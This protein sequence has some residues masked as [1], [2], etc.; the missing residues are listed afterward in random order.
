MQSVVIIGG[1][2][3]IGR[4]LAL[5][6]S[7][8]Q[9]VTATYCKTPQENSGNLTYVSQDVLNDFDFPLPESVDH[10]V[11]CPGA[12]NLKPFHA[13]K[14]DSFVQDY[15]LQVVGAVK[16]IQ[17]CLKLLKKSDQASITLFSSVASQTGFPFHSQV[18]ASKGAIEGL[19][20]A[21]AAELSPKIRVNVIAPSLT[22]TPLANHFIN[23]EAKIE[24]NKA[25]HPMQ[26]I[27]H[28]QDITHA[29]KYLQS[30]HWVT[31]QVIKVDGGISSIR[32]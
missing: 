13:L 4:D 7:K 27:G 23:N 15:Q 30:A 9:A 18:S 5:E 16:A 26:A 19:A 24:A 3:G 6:L 14:P 17:Y 2:T 20:V 11:Y 29:Y 10:I 1:S 28:T 12:I 21:L 22:D 31:G 32:K 8:T 25:R